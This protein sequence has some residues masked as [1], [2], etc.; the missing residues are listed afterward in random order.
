MVKLSDKH[1]VA[2]APQPIVIQPVGNG[3]YHG[4][5]GWHDHRHLDR[6][7]R[8]ISHIISR[9]TYRQSVTSDPEPYSDQHITSLGVSEYL[10]KT[11]MSNFEVSDVL[12][13][14]GSVFEDAAYRY[15]DGW[16]GYMHLNQP[17]N[18]TH[19]IVQSSHIQRS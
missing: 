10:G 11:P 9:M 1:A 2:D 13:H 8:D 7:W 3:P 12:H 16:H 18:E 6:P 14:R 17:W 4:V 15:A 5:D 19:P